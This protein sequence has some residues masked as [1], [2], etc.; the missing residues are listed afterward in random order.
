MHP[1]RVQIRIDEIAQKDECCDAHVSDCLEFW[2]GGWVLCQTNVQTVH[3]CLLVSLG[4]TTG[5]VYQ[6]GRNP[7]RAISA[8]G[9][10]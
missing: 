5:T 3:V 10:K 2:W 4:P 6:P 7:P 9:I 1:L 8:S